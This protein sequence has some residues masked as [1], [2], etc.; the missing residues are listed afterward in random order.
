M[1]PRRPESPPDN[2]MGIHLLGV[3]RATIEGLEAR[4]RAFMK[5][6][7]PEPV[8]ECTPEHPRTHRDESQMWALVDNH[9]NTKWDSG[10]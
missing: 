5:A 4:V 3:G 10:R 1:T 2:T 7:A 6:G 8:L 9:L